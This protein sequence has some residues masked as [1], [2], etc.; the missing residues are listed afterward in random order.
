ME[1]FYLV[2]QTITV[3]LEVA[4]KYYILECGSVDKW[5]WYNASLGDYL[6]SA[7]TGLNFKALA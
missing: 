5:K 3:S 2:E 6:D 1:K 7:A 4:N